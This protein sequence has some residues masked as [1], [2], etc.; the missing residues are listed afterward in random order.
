MSH[1]G[2]VVHD[3][4]EKSDI[5]LEILDARF[6]E[7]TRNRETEYKIKNTNK[8]LIHV[9]NKCDFVDKKGLDAAKKDL[10]NCVFVSAKKHLG[11]TLLR[12]KIKFLAKKYKIKNP[13]IGVIGYPNVGKSSLINALKGKGSAP[14]SSEAGHTKG[15]QYLRI[16]ESIMMIDTPGIIGK[17]ASNDENLVLIGA[18]NPEIIED[19]DLVVFKLM[20]QYPGLLEKTYGVEV[21]NSRPRVLE[22]IAVKLNMLKKGGLPDIERASR[23]ILQDWLKGKIKDPSQYSFSR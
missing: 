10:E 7:K 13:I 20:K 15:K 12:Q 16:S 9:I 21:K 2:W 22:Y 19:P 23:K 8:I 4:I 1:F 3:V 18:K 17:G 6:I 5:V 14:T 11:T